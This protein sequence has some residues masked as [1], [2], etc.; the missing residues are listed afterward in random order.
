M[1]RPSPAFR[2]ASGP[3]TMPIWLYALA[4]GGSAGASLTLLAAAAFPVALERC[5]RVRV[6]TLAL[7]L[8]SIGL[9]GLLVVEGFAP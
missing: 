4:L 3:A 9:F 8:L 5:S 6:A 1:N 2:I 7:G